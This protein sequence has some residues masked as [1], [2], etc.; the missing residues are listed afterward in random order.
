MY[1][2]GYSG[3]NK[4][5]DCGRTKEVDCRWGEFKIARVCNFEHLWVG[6]GL[7]DPPPIRGLLYFDGA[8]SCEGEGLRH[9]F[10]VGRWVRS[11][12]C[13]RLD[14]RPAL[15]AARLKYTL[16]GQERGTMKCVACSSC[17]L[18][19]AIPACIVTTVRFSCR[20]S[21]HRLRRSPSNRP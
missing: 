1:R 15:I 2:W 6:C 8:V 14:C 4:I 5:L 16:S 3:P 7:Y 21:L 19:D 17:K 12:L 13:V 20:L 9:R 10:P 18:C 11:L